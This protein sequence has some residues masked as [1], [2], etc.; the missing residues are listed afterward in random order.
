MDYFLILHCLIGIDQQDE[1]EDYIT[2]YEDILREN[3][4]LRGIMF[5][6]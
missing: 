4:D 6:F 3:P 2:F 5:N 1:A